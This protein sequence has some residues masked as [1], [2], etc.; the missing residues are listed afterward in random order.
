MDSTV[1]DIAAPLHDH[2][3]LGLLKVSLP[4]K[5]VAAGKEAGDG[6]ALADDLTVDLQHGKLAHGA[7]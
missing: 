7:L 1:H 3:D 5:S 6:E 4:S 2:V